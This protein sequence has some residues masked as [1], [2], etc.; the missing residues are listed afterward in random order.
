MEGGDPGAEKL[1]ICKAQFIHNGKPDKWGIIELYTELSTIST[2]SGRFFVV[3][4]G[5]FENGC[6]VEKGKTAFL[7]KKQLTNKYSK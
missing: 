7:R 1:S 4:I 2:F 5:F 6:F 3:Y